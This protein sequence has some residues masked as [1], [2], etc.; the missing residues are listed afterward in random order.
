MR[1]GFRKAFPYGFVKCYHA[2]RLP[3]LCASDNTLLQGLEAGHRAHGYVTGVKDY[4]VFIAFCGAV[5]GLVPQAEL[6]LEP[7]QDAT[8]HFP[9]GKVCFDSGLLQ[10]DPSSQLHP[11]HNPV[12]K[13][14]FM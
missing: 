2:V 7:N 9:N 10:K 6:G 4:G 14:D 13:E 8:T 1:V 5:K 12:Y 11:C 3:V